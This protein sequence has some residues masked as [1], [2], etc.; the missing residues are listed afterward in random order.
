[1]NDFL[2]KIAGILEVESVQETDNL[3]D[4]PQWDSLTVLSI[5][6]MLDSDWGVNLSAADFQG[7]TTAGDLWNVV[8]TKKAA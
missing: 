7:I 2:K 4:F 5:I 8:Q 6:A 3:K 1:M